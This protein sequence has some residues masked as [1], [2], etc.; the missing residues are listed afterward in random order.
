MFLKVPLKYIM[1]LAIFH[2]RG[3]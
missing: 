2:R 3:F 1:F